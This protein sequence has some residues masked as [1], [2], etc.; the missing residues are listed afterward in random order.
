MP[1]VTQMV[2][3]RDQSIQSGLRP[4]T[5]RLWPVQALWNLRVL[6]VTA[7]T[8]HMTDG[9]GRTHAPFLLV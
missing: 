1:E 5:D 2:S 3:F 9:H 6:C 8:W 7:F 4:R